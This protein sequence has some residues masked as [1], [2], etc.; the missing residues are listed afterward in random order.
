MAWTAAFRRPAA[1]LRYTLGSSGSAGKTFD[2][3]VDASVT[4]RDVRE[5]IRMVTEGT[6]SAPPEEV[7]AAYMLRAFHEMWAPGT[8]LQ[9]PE[10]PPA[11]P[12][13]AR[14]LHTPHPP[15][16]HYYMTDGPHSAER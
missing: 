7:D 9:Y 12:T 14:P 16:L 15:P 13:P 3:V 11:P 8:Q 1:F 10:V 5:L 2:A 6:C 4:R